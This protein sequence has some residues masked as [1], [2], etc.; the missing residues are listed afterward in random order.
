MFLWPLIR[1]GHIV[2][3]FAE[4]LVRLKRGGLAHKDTR[5]MATPLATVQAKEAVP[6]TD[7]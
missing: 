3:A 1:S 4:V 2:D 7:E 5:A 6:K